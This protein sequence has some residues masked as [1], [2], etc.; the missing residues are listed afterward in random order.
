MTTSIKEVRELISSLNTKSATL[1]KLRPIKL[2][3]SSTLGLVDSGN[4]FYNA[5][6]LSLLLP[7]SA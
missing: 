4:S 3:A 6:S 1:N 5:L 2:C 7:K